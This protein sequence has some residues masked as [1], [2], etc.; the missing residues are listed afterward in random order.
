[1]QMARGE[2]RRGS[3]PDPG[4]DRRR[5][6]FSTRHR[7]RGRSSVGPVPLRQRSNAGR[8]A[9]RRSLAIPSGRGARRSLSLPSRQLGPARDRPGRTRMRAAALRGKCDPGRRGSE[10]HG[11][12]SSWP[13]GQDDARS[14]GDGG[15]DLWPSRGSSSSPKGREDAG[16][17]AVDRDVGD[18][19]GRIR[20]RLLAGEDEEEKREDEKEEEEAVIS[21]GRRQRDERDVCVCVCVC[22]WA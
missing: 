16:K 8:K 20:R 17:L 6:R 15:V 13:R 11:H 7:R 19:D 22:V 2:R 12:A 1:M 21:G 9:G 4:P 5:S 10:S 14:S 18:V 3:G